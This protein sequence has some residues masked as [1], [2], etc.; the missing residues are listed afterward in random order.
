M[1]DTKSNVKWF[2][3]FRPLLTNN[4]CKNNP[5]GIPYIANAIDCLKSVDIDF[6]AFKNEVKDSRKRT[7]V[8]ADMLSYDDGQQKLAFDANDISVY[9]LPKGTSKDDLIQSDTE[10]L[11]TRK[12]VVGIK[13][14]FKY[15]RK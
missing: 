7:F 9:V 13:Y 5:F 14:K 2:S 15:F 1:F 4:V 3:I 8:R 11:R 6:D 12:L 10:N